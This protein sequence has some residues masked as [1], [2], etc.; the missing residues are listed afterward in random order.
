MVQIEPV[1]SAPLRREFVRCAVRFYRDL[2]AWV[3]PFEPEY[4]RLLD[5]KR[6]SFFRVP[7]NAAAF[8]LAR[9]NGEIVGRIGAFRNVAH[10]TANHDA[11]GFFG[12]FE[13]V[14]EPEVARL[15]LAAAEHWLRAQGLRIARGPAN[16]NI[17]E[18]AGVL[19]DAFDLQ[20]MIGMTY[21]PAYYRGL[22]EAA[23]YRKC[24]DLLV[25]RVNQEEAHFER[26]ERIAAAVAQR[27]AV[28]VRPLDVNH[29]EREAVC[30]EKIFADSWQDNWGVVPISAGEFREM[31]ERY[32]MFLIPDLVYLAEVN[33]EPAGAIVT[34]PDLNVLVKA[35]GGRLWPFGWWHMLMGRKRVTRFRT[36]M[37][38]VRPKFRRLGLP[39]IFI[40][41]CRAEMMRRHA[42]E[43]EFS[44]ILE[45]N[46][47]IISILKEVGSRP[48]QT[49]RLYEKDLP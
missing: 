23:D 24:R 49:L 15:L 25:Y 42:T 43:A 47:E 48:V 45:D 17:Q 34:M 12:L 3:P 40:S 30:F 8:F 41:R 16:F 44:W 22:L 32:R 21:T 33:G 29:L 35:A 14:N 1:D 28:Q 20:P 18:E 46:H 10:L 13:C 27:T 19:L 5:P 39:L 37:M 31:Y 2:P 9:R 36:L 7:G 38:G 6:N 4:I 11:A 26:I